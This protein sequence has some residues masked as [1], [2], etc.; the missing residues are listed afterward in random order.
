MAKKLLSYSRFP[1]IFNLAVNCR[2][3][4]YAGLTQQ[5]CKQMRP[6][7]NAARLQVLEEIKKGNI[8]KD[9]YNTEVVYLAGLRLVDEKLPTSVKKD[10]ST[11]VK[12]G[13]I[14]LL[15][16]DG[17]YRADVYHHPMFEKEAKA[18]QDAHAKEKRDLVSSVLA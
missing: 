2:K 5:R 7:I 6:S 11:G 14:K 10:L 13:R 8:S 18:K 16:G 3:G 9:Q 1:A 17:K 4:G 12:E 15:K